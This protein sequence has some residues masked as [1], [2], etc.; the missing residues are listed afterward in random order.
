MNCRGCFQGHMGPARMGVEGCRIFRA[1]MFESAQ[2]PAARPLH[3]PHVTDFGAPTPDLRSSTVLGGQS[4]PYEP[5]SAQAPPSLVEP[6]LPA[7]AGPDG[8][9]F[10]E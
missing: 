10:V 2:L 5:V 4:W 7:V 1:H 8:E 6:M 3:C 9:W